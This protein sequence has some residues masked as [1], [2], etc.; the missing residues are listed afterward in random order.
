MNVVTTSGLNEERKRTLMIYA[1]NSWFRRAGLKVSILALL[2]IASACGSSDQ[3]NPSSDL[4][5]DGAPGGDTLATAPVDSSAIPTDTTLIGAIDSAVR[6]DSTGLATLNALIPPGIPFG[7]YNL[8]SQYLT[9]VLNSSMQGIDPPYL[10]DQLKRAHEK[11]GRMILRMTG[12][13]AHRI[14]NANGTF[15]F[16]KW[17]NLVNE[18]T[19]YNF[20]S[21]ISDGTLIGH[22]LIDEPQNASRWGGKT[23][24]HATVEAM[25]KYSKD[26]WPGLTTFARVAPTWLAGATITYTSLDAGWAQYAAYQGDAAG[27][28]AK[29][30]AAAKR[31]GLGLAVGM[32]VLD[33]GNGSSK[34]AG[35]TKGKYKMS[36]TEVKNYGTALL[37]QSYS[38]SF[39]NWTYIDGGAE[40]FARAD[41]SASL[42]F[43]STKAKAHVRTS[44]RQ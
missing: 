2:G 41:V 32:N 3:L 35:W 17:K 12:G 36:A 28:I 1:V 24:P 6:V 39:F 16:T 37:N 9:S 30:V 5:L 7:A 23:I 18:Y 20:N 34:V 26:R 38:C 44:C 21:Y 31:K 14:K 19:K 29:E 10:M 22:F 11:G 8:K 43:L 25:A 40:Y 27:W 42:T 33:G 13:P 15:S 4:P